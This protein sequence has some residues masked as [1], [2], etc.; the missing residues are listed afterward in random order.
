MFQTRP[1]RSRFPTVRKVSG[2]GSEQLA[3]AEGQVKRL[4]TVQT[5]VAHRLVAIVEV[6]VADRFG[7]AE[8]LGDVVAGQLDVHPARP[9]P[10]LA[11]GGEEPGDLAQDHLEVARLAPGLGG[12]R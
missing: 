5:G 6:L 7:A 9:R 8:A 2:T 11:M 4:A 3:D 12:E 1:P 10:D